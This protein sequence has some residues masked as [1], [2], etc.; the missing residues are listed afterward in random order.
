MVASN[1]RWVRR[2]VGGGIAIVVLVAVAA[3]AGLISP[4]G[5]AAAEKDQADKGAVAPAA[6]EPVA[7]T[8]E[9]LTQREVQRTVQ[10]VGSFNAHVKVTVTAEVQGRVTK[11]YCD[12]GDLVGTGD[13]L[14]EIDP[15][16]YEL[17]VLACRTAFEAELAK[18]VPDREGR[19]PLVEKLNRIVADEGTRRELAAKFAKQGS[20]ALLERATQIINDL[21]SV[22]RAAEQ[23]KN[24][25]ARLKRTYQ[26]RE[27][28]QGA[29]SDEE[30][31]QRETECEV[32]RE[33]RLQAVLDAEATLA[34]ASY[35][36]ATLADV[37]QKLRYTRVVVPDSPVA[38][39]LVADKLIDKVQY[40]VSK[41]RVDEGEMVKD[42]INSTAAVF[43]LVLDKVLKFCG[44]VVEQHAGTVKLG[45][46]VALRVDAYPGEVFWG[47]IKRV[48]PT[49]DQASPTFQI[50]ATVLNADRRLKPG[51][52]AK[53]EVLTYV[54]RR[55]KTVPPH[56]I[57]TFAGS[58]KVFVV[59]GGKNGKEAHAVLVTLGTTGP[60]WTEVTPKETGKL[61]DDAL[62]ITSGL[63]QLVEGTPIR[64]RGDQGRAAT[65]GRGLA[66][67]PEGPEAPIPNP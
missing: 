61:P 56:A 24:A 21:P 11:I 62:I 65:T 34:M 23:E 45:Q 64:V 33:T 31:E 57:I 15:T 52:F 41:R 48:S 17:A 1:K 39:R 36:L 66:D 2:I 28:S 12:V 58:D 27:K 16:D 14:L 38:A 59:R 43:D 22:K 55:G 50:E 8:V 51:G 7:V 47:T 40:A 42:S 32:A 4:F 25:Q 9:K 37:E 10:T 49:V 44:S 35:R 20:S 30:I 54:D 19:R 13:P 60:G 3:M 18:L 46:K 26:T 5:K 53:G 63:S 29:I 67:A 6:R